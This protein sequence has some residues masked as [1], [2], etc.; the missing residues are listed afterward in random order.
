MKDQLV[1][2]SMNN[3]ST[4]HLWDDMRD[5][6]YILPNISI[7]DITCTVVWSPYKVE[8]Q[9]ASLSVVVRPI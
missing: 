2:M 7:R 1:Y 4:D 6:S 5:A 8:L 3:Y 9:A